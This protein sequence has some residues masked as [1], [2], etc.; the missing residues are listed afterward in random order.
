M[1]TR[2]LKV[3]PKGKPLMGAP[4]QAGVARLWGTPA[5]NPEGAW[6]DP[7]STAYAW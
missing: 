2:H 3:D 4:A 5:E 7:L 1:N 6:L